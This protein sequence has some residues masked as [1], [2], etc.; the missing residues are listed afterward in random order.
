[1]G[2]KWMIALVLAGALVLSGSAF[3]DHD[4]DEDHDHGHGHG[5]GNPHARHDDD[6]WEHRG[7]YDYHVFEGDS[8]PPGWSHGKKTGWGNCGLP[9]GQAKKYGC[10]TYVYQGTPYYYY[11]DDAG[12]VVVRRPSIHI[13]G[14]ID[15]P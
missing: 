5:K 13:Q 15:I 2:K 14:S 8:R 12:R 10:Q 1:M 4:R 9:P 6:Q 11:Q 7:N 3:A